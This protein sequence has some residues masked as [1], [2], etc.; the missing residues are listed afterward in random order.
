MIADPAL[1]ISPTEQ[2]THDSGSSTPPINHNPNT[3]G[4]PFMGP[5]LGLVKAMGDAKS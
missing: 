1:F 3:L 2:I 4:I 5:V